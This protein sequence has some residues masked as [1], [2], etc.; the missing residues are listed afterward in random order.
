MKPDKAQNFIK[1]KDTAMFKEMAETNDNLEEIKKAVKDKVVVEIGEVTGFGDFGKAIDSFKKSLGAIQ[2]I[3]G[4][5]GHTPSN[6]ELVNLITPLIPKPVK[7][8]DG[9]DAV[10]DYERVIREVLS[11]IELPEVNKQ[12]IIDEVVTQLPTSGDAIRDSLEL[13]QKGE[14]L[15][16]DAI[17][18]KKGRGLDE[19][20]QD[21]YKRIANKVQHIGGSIRLWVSEEDGNPDIQTSKIRF[22]NGSVTQNADDTVSVTITAEVYT[23]DLSSQVDNVLKVFTVPAH[24]RVLSVTC[25]DFPIIYRPVVDFTTSGTTLTLTAEVQPPSLSATLLFTYIV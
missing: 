6:R 15:Y 7:G 24:T 2:K 16:V 17:E 12:E 23:S 20:I 25:T 18:S 21:L 13:L 8:E 10:V 3:E 11:E 1:D 9:Q 14:R 4:K 5:D 19:I 22:P